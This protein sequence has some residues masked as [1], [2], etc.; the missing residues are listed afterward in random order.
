MLLVFFFF[1]FCLSLFYVFVLNDNNGE[2]VP[3]WTVIVGW[4][5]S[6]E[7]FS[8]KMPHARDTW[9]FDHS[10]LFFLHT[11]PCMAYKFDN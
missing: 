2:H 6:C 1:N 3:L 4:N 8:M 7:P 5:D 10:L 9:Y 11:P